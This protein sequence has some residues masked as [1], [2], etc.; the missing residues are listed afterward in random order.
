MRKNRF[1]NGFYTTAVATFNG[2]KILTRSMFYKGL[3]C[4]CVYDKYL[5]GLCLSSFHLYIF[6][7]YIYEP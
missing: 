1:K 6:I 7:A 4:V 2:E 5:F 3:R